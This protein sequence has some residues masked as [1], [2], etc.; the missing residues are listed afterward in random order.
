MFLFRFEEVAPHVTWQKPVIKACFVRIADFACA[1][2]LRQARTSGLGKLHRSASQ[3]PTG[4][5]GPELADWAVRA[6]VAQTVFEPMIREARRQH[7]LV[8]QHYGKV[9]LTWVFSNM[10]TRLYVGALLLQRVTG[11]YHDMQVRPFGGS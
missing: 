3:R 6:G 8:S 5:F 4:S 1:T 11:W 2:S 10:T 7:M 9:E